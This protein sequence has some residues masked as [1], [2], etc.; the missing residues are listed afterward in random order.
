MDGTG[1]LNGMNDRDGA[2]LVRRV[3]DGTAAA[4]AGIRPGDV[5]LN[6]GGCDVHS[7]WC[8]THAI[9]LH[10]ESQPFV[11]TW[12]RPS[13]GQIMQTPSN[14]AAAGTKQTPHLPPAHDKSAAAKLPLIRPMAL[15]GYFW[16]S[17]GDLILT[18]VMCRIDALK[19]ALLH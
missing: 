8:I 15:S 1:P 13:A 14:L 7:R 17:F 18:P 16:L 12:Y 19:W 5:L 11:A 9:D 6:L 2:L 4:K 10:T 3:T